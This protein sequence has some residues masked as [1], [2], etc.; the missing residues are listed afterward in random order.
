MNPGSKS[1]RLTTGWL[2]LFLRKRL[3]K[4][5][6]GGDGLGGGGGKPVNARAV[7]SARSI[8]NVQV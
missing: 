5:R 8:I 3:Q 1:L 7:C 2:K 6:I 4:T